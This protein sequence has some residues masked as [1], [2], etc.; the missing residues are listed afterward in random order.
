MK[1]FN[2][3]R[4][5][6]FELYQH[7]GLTWYQHDL[8]LLPELHEE[9]VPHFTFST[10]VW[11]MVDEVHCYDNLPSCYVREC[12]VEY[13]GD[14]FIFEVMAVVEKAQ[15]VVKQIDVYTPAGDGVG[16]IHHLFSAKLHVS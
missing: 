12:Q 9:K 13:H 2:Q 15:I 1:K 7:T 6:A 16:G 3:L 4:I 11:V 8:L 5:R 10:N 14:V